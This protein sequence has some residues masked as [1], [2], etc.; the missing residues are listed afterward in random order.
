MA[1]QGYNFQIIHKAGK[2][3]IVD[4]ISR[5]DLENQVKNDEHLLI[6]VPKINLSTNV[7]KKNLSTNTESP[8]VSG[9]D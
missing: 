7:P 6:N 8:F 2:E 1:L 9:R 3:N 5:L 4:F